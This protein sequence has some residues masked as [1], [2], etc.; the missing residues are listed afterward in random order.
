MRDRKRSN[1]SSEQAREGNHLLRLD[2]TKTEPPPSLFRCPISLEVMRSPVSLCTGVTY[3]RSSIQ[4]WLDSGNTTCPAT[5]QPLPSTDLVP[6]L[7]LR[8]LIHF[9]SSSTSSSDQHLLSL[10]DL[11][12]ILSD[13][14][15]EEG[16]KL[17]L[18]SSDL[19]HPSVVAPLFLAP[20]T[21]ELAVTLV[22]LLLSLDLVKPDNK[23][24]LI[25]AILSDLETTIS[26]IVN[27]FKGADQSSSRVA[28][29]RVLEMLITEERTV[30][31]EKPDLMTELVR[32]LGE[33]DAELVNAGLRC[34]MG[35]IGAGR[36]VK[37]AMVRMGLVPALTKVMEREGDGIPV[38]VVTRAMRFMESAAGCG[39][40]RAAI[41]AEAERCIA[42]VVGMMMK[43]GNEGREAAVAVLWSVCCAG[44]GDRRAR[45]AAA[46]T[47]G[48]LAKILV[49]MQGDCSISARKM[50]GDLLRVFRGNDKS[51][52]G[53]AGYDSKTI[54]IMPF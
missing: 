5:R 31:A 18:L 43:V 38:S 23:R 27:V 6:N 48:G 25:K 12:R 36:R 3:D 14:D 7:T 45:E 17:S 21:L 37:V 11:A 50:A 46:E 54:H 49:L 30:I 26:G 41:C 33:S 35:L 42:A 15:V 52:V 34:L 2:V 28:A 39:E 13:P 4:R 8:R 32:L 29:A 51:S 22:S 10:S 16:Y 53:G 44:G 1:N 9:W 24:A 40:G 47:K 19:L 20:K